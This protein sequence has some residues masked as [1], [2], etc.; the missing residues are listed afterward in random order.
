MI[1]RFW[2]LMTCIISLVTPSPSRSVVGNSD[3]WAS[4]LRKAEFLRASE[5]VLLVIGWGWV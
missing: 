3:Y 2:A 5:E 1:S 4:S